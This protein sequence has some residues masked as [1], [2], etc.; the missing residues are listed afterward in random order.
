[1]K[2]AEQVEQF[3]DRYLELARNNARLRQ[4]LAMPDGCIIR[5]DARVYQIN[6]QNKG[7]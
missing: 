1:M 6:A 4:Y 3:S 7:G 2:S 5:V